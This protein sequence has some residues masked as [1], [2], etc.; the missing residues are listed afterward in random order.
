MAS[1][2]PL[3][4]A[5]PPEPA[6]F[7]PPPGALAAIF[8]I[9][10]SDFLGFGLIIPA[11]PF[12]VRKFATTDL[13]IGLIA[14]TFSL[15]QLVATPILGA[16]SDRFGR[17]PILLLS[18]IGSVIGYVLLA[19]AVGFHW[20]NPLH[21]LILL[22]V[23]RSIDGFSGGNVSTAQAY[24]SDV[25]TP[26]N[27]AKGMGLI[28][29]AFGIGFS[30][31]PAIGG[32][33]AWFH[34]SGPAI[35]AAL[36]CSA[37][38]TMTF[39]RLKEPMRHRHDEEAEAWLHP[40]RFAP[41][42]RNPLLLQLL[43]IFF[44]SM[45]G[46]VMV[47]TVFAIY[48]A[49][50]YKFSVLAVG[51]FFLWFGLIIAAVQGGL[52]GRMVRMFGEWPLVICGPISV[53]VAMFFYASIGWFL[54]PVALGVVLVLFAGLLNAGGRSSQ[55]PTLSSLI[56]RAADERMQGTVFGFFH[57]LGSLGR[58]IGPMIAT[59][60]YIHH[61]T[62]PFMLAAGMMVVIAG[63]TIALRT[64]QEKAAAAVPA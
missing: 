47:E 55:G 18:Q 29:A 26:E 53:M 33:L 59:A 19:I 27:R 10:L 63:W 39:I 58:V 56:S 20:G 62:A 14:A 31:G 38:A 37:A 57:M 4:Y 24:V 43:A 7:E 21:G 17:R 35:A 25:T 36:A 41:I 48:M 6:P 44:F 60:L 11:L 16:A 52:I 9:V 8:L 15:C 22:Y 40:S 61:H 13:Q 46:F 28:G 50:T 1:D 45:I 42:F 23:A 32:I 30:L 5:T 54:P 34:D 3:E 49:D 2:A 51:M 64:G 12:Y